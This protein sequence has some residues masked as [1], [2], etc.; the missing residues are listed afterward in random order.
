MLENREDL[1]M[2]NMKVI[3]KKD[4]PTLGEEGDIKV[5]KKGYARN[6]LFPNGLVLEFNKHNRNILESRKEIIE[7]KKEQKRNDAVL[8]KEKLEK[9]IV[10]IEMPSGDK[11]R[12]Y[13]TVTNTN[14][15]DELAK[16]EYNIEKKN[17]ELIEHIKFS[18]N[19]KYR[20]HLY[21]DIYAEMQLEV[22]AIKEKKKDE[23]PYKKAKGP[24]RYHDDMPPQ[25]T[26]P[27]ENIQDAESK[28]SAPEKTK[29]TEAKPEPESK[30]ELKAE[31]KS[32]PKTKSEAEPKS[33]TEAK[34]ESK[35][36]SKSKVKS[37][38]KTKSEVKK[39]K[40]TSEEEKK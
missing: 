15:S 17:I 24:Q 1:D 36:E 20:I 12:L 29:K 33:D 22:V 35:P 19:Y 40:K 16:V 38:T 37:E 7:K 13:G 28:K 23:R 11:G 6:F 8:L 21:Q 34:P 5:V 3:L 10:K 26:P 9:E 27:E 39:E 14:I 31:A 32:E 4:M 18:G 2:G 30:A 25:D